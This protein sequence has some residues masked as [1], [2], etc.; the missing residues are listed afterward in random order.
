MPGFHHVRVGKFF[1]WSEK[2]T[3]ISGKE[4]RGSEEMEKNPEKTKYIL[5]IYVLSYTSTYYLH[6]LQI[7]Q[8]LKPQIY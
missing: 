7:T 5:V 1:P 2:S 6:V 3:E 4:K 8:E